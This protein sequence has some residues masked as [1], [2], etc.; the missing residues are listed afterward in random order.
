MSSTEAPFSYTEKTAAG[1]LFTIRGTDY[2]EFFGNLVA[3]RDDP[4]LVEVLGAVHSKLAGAAAVAVDPAP[5]RGSGYQR[6]SHAPDPSSTHNG[7][8]FDSGGGACKHGE[9]VAKSGSKN[10][11]DWSGWF[12]P[13]S[14]RMCAPVWNK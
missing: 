2:D 4:E 11:R 5:A 14:D 6:R 3:V 12:C 1:N 7:E 8:G 10:G 13:N 9:R